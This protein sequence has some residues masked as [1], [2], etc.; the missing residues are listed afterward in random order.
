MIL[1][2]LA[3]AQAPSVEACLNASER[4]QVALRGGRYLAARDG[5]EVCVASSCPAVVRRDCRARLKATQ[6]KLASAVVTVVDAD[7][8]EL[9]ARVQVDGRSYTNGDPLDP[10]EH[11]VK[12]TANGTTH[13]GALRLAEG[14]RDHAVEIVVAPPPPPPAIVAEPTPPDEGVDVPSIALTA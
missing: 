2:L 11:R 8:R 6:N 7:G 5:F 10:G 14:Q 12:V 1:L 13:E 3:L 4:A 9:E